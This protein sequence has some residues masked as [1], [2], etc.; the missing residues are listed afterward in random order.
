MLLK[1]YSGGRE[2]NANMTGRFLSLFFLDLGPFASC[3]VKA[4][5]GEEWAG[6]VAARGLQGALRLLSLRTISSGP[7]H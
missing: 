3:D 6:R 7:L 4:A 5:A 1:A 2:I